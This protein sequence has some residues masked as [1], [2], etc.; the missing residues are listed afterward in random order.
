MIESG[1][2]AP[3]VCE[4]RHTVEV[5]RWERLASLVHPEIRWTTTTEEDLHGPVAAMRQLF[6]RKD[7]PAA[8]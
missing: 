5:R 8:R 7:T 3:P 6:R 4:V 2:Q 1:Q